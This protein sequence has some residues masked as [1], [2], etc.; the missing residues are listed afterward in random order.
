M[1]KSHSIKILCV[2][3]SMGFGMAFVRNNLSETVGVVKLACHDMGVLVVELSPAHLKKIIAGHGKAK[4]THI[5]K[6]VVAAFNLKT[7]GAE[8]E[9]DAVALALTCYIDLG[10]KGY[11]INVPFS[12]VK[13]KKVKPKGASLSGK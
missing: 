9:C 11:K 7:A 13:A 1:V 10:W 4:K 3:R 12:K 2:E 8:H 5:K 6:N